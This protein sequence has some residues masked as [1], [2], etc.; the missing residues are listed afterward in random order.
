MVAQSGAASSVNLAYYWPKRMTAVL[1][2]LDT[3]VSIYPTFYETYYVCTALS[4][5]TKHAR[6]FCQL[7]V[8]DPLAENALLSSRIG[9]EMTQDIY[10]IKAAR[11]PNK[12]TLRRKSNQ[13]RKQLCNMRPSMHKGN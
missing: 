9:L 4:R 7:R 11:S 2:Q 10:A 1:E 5:Y 12:D 3:H 13:E 8:R 6:L